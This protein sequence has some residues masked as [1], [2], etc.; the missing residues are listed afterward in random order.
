M[1][2]EMVTPTSVAEA[3][4]I[5]KIPTRVVSFMVTTVVEKK[6]ADK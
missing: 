5:V 2:T 1:S 4:A 6:R 3:R